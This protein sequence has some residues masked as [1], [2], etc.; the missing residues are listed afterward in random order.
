MLWDLRFC[1]IFVGLFE[2]VDS[3]QNVN[4][5]A[6]PDVF[7]RTHIERFFEQVHLKRQDDGGFERSKKTPKSLTSVFLESE[8]SDM[9]DFVNDEEIGTP[10][11]FMC[12]A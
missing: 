4:V 3:G 11:R 12:V 2:Q 5:S 10:P 6:V 1:S 9:V 7:V 8:I